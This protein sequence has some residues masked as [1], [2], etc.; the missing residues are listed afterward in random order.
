MENINLIIVA[1]EIRWKAHITDGGRNTVA[2]ANNR[3]HSKEPRFGTLG[4]DGKFQNKSVGVEKRET[5]SRNTR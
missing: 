3:L 5:S 1:E 2:T 4:F